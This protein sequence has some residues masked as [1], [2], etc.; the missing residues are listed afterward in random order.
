A[1]A[2]LRALLGVVLCSLMVSASEILPQADFD[3]QGVRIAGKWCLT[4]VCSNFKWFAV[5]KPTGSPAMVEPTE[6][7]LKTDMPG[8][9]P[10]ITPTK[11]GNRFVTE[12]RVV[13]GKPDEYGLNHYINTGRRE[14][15]VENRLYGKVAFSCAH[16]DLSA[17][18]KFNQLCLQTG[19][20]P[21]NILPSIHPS[22]QCFSSLFIL[23]MK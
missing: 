11:T 2:S 22:I 5:T 12:M 3:L 1:M 20:L 21:A 18:E 9:F 23:Y 19:I 4:G 8:N 16:L 15:F 13:D 10:V 14:T 17:E 6:D 7:G